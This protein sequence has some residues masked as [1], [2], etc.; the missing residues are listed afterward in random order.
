VVKTNWECN[1]ISSGTCCCI[2]DQLMPDVLST[3]LIFEGSE[4]HFFMGISTLEKSVVNQP[5][6]Q[7][8]IPEEWRPQLH[9]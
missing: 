8:H 5:G 1:L 4:D 2:T 9:R 7:R 3:G 6:M